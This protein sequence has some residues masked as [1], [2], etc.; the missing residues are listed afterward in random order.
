MCAVFFLMPQKTMN[1]AGAN[2]FFEEFLWPCED[3]TVRYE[4][5]RIRRNYSRE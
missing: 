1:D 2:N 5:E 3:L 4:E